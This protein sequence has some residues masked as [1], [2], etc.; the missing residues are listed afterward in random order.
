MK[1]DDCK[2][3]FFF[4]DLVTIKGRKRIDTRMEDGHMIRTERNH[5]ACWTCYQD[6]LKVTDGEFYKSDLGRVV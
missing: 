5:Q 4:M 2:E 3:D 6:W 1:C